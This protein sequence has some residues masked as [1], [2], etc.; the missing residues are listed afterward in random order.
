MCVC[1]CHAKNLAE[2]D[3]AYPKP[4]IGGHDLQGSQP[5]WAW[6]LKPDMVGVDSLG[7]SLVAVVSP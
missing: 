4:S 7:T 2:V 1:V 6:S 5:G 3:M